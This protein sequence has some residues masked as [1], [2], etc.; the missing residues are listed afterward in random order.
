[1]VMARIN[2]KYDLSA[3]QEEP[4]VL[5]F[6][7]TRAIRMISQDLDQ[8]YPGDAKIVIYNAISDM[9]DALGKQFEN[10]MQGKFDQYLQYSQ[11]R[12]SDRGCYGIIFPDEEGGSGCPD[13]NTDSKSRS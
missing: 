6:E 8:T 10:P 2:D 4:D 11:E 7:L 13:T 5:V 3:C 12:I 1:M 9:Y